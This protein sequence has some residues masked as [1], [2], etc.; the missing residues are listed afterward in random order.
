MFLFEPLSGYNVISN[1]F[2]EDIQKN[3]T[4]NLTMGDIKVDS[5]L[6]ESLFQEKNLKRLPRN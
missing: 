3:H 1:I 4:T 5:G 2:V 6:D